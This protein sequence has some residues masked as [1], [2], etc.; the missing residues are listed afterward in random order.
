VEGSKEEEVKVEFEIDDSLTAVSGVA[1][2]SCF[3]EDGEPVIV[4]R[5]F[6]NTRAVEQIG[7]LTAALDQ[8]RYTFIDKDFEFEDEEDDEQ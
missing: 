6:S 2:I 3:G 7:L 1:V 8:T 4:Q 5:A